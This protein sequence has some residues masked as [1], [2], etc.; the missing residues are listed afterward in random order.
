M[1]T[2]YFSQVFSI[3]HTKT[4][5]SNRINWTFFLLCVPGRGF[6]HSLLADKNQSNSLPDK[7]KTITFAKWTLVKFDPRNLYFFKR[8]YIFLPN[9]PP[10]FFIDT[11]PKFTFYLADIMPC[12]IILQRCV[13]FLDTSRCC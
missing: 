10:R 3:Y 5:S 4:K 13:L 8:M 7:K 1:K 6:L 9:F 2:K 11:S 12:Y